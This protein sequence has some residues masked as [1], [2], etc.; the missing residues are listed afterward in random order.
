MQP[1]TY[2]GKPTLHYDPI[3]IINLTLAEYNEIYEY[4]FNYQC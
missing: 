4:L 1:M 3:V 2:I